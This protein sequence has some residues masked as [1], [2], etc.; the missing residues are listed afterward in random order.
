MSPKGKALASLME[1]NW[2]QTIYPR[3]GKAEDV[4]QAATTVMTS[5]SYRL[6]AGGKK[7]GNNKAVAKELAIFVSAIS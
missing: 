3:V 2:S 1:V 4:A 7:G 6:V 5:I